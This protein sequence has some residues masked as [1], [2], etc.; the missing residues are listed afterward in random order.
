VGAVV[1]GLILVGGCPH[2]DAG[3]PT[4]LIPGVDAGAHADGDGGVIPGVDGAIPAGPDGAIPAGPDG[5]IPA[6]PDG[7]IPAVPG[8]ALCEQAAPAFCDQ[9]FR[10]DPKGAKESYGSVEGCYVEDASTCRWWGSLPDANPKGDGELGSV[11]QGIRRADLRARERRPSPRRVS[12]ARRRAQGRPS[13]HRPRAMR[14]QLLQ[15][16]RRS[17]HPEG[18]LQRLCAAAGRR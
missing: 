5:A 3:T 11:Q 18:H 9:Y 10:C 2:K 16:H 1:A 4:N 14:D 8:G 17:H 12:N 15:G 6:G 13:V 7:A